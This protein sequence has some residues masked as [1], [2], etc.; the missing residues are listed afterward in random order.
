[1][2]ESDAAER[3]RRAAEMH[4]SFESRS[5]GRYAVT[6]TVF[7]ADVTVDGADGAAVFDVTVQVPMLDAVTA[8]HVAPVVED[9]WFDT[10]SLRVDDVDGV[11]RGT[12]DV[13]VAV[14]RDGD[15][16]TVEVEL[17]DID[18]GRAADNAVAIVEYVEGTYVEGVI[19]GYDYTEPVTHLIQRA[20]DAGGGTQGGTPL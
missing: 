9:G 10:F 11:L 12:D 2:T 7:D 14:E 20:A 1:M 3:A 15:E 19:P 6:T 8:D 5:E 18:P 16:A 4:D 17:V 13:A